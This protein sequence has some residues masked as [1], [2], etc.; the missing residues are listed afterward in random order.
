MKILGFKRPLQNQPADRS[1][2]HC[3]ARI[4]GET[5][6]A[7]LRAPGSR[8]SRFVRQDSAMTLIEL[9]VVCFVV[10]ILTMMFLPTLARPHRSSKIACTNNL[11]QTG[12]AFRI[13]AGDNNDK[14]PMEISVT[15]G[16]A[17]E[18]METT[19]AWIA[20]QVMSNE[21]STPKVL[22]CPADSLPGN[23]ATNFS[24]DLKNKISYFIG[25]DA[26]QTNNNSI[27]SG[28][29]NF[30]LAGVPVKSG[31]F[32]FAS[33]APVAWTKTRHQFSG[34]LALGDGSVL[35]LNNSGLTNQIHQ[36]GLATNRIFIP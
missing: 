9:I 29:D 11:K 1:A 36:T 33:N 20:F 25:L 12:L 27:L 31:G 21:L 13:W 35:S 30:S 4:I 14:F 34:N 26:V 5:R 32:Y 24:D 23:Y 17:M 2:E 15:N 10:A 6:E 19:N 3:S 8:P 28:D 7:M 18:W 16:G 22:L